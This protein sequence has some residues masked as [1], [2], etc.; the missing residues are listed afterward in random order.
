MVLFPCDNP[1]EILISLSDLFFICDPEY[2]YFIHK[3][4]VSISMLIIV[5]MLLFVCKYQ[6]NQKEE[7][8]KIITLCML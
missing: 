3:Q 7:G 2:H 1:T 4:S 5:F 6:I 8:K